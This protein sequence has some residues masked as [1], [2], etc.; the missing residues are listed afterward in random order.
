LECGS[1][2]PLFLLGG[3]NLLAG[4]TRRAAMSA[5]KLATG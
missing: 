3:T 4:M 5:S 2:L 1:L